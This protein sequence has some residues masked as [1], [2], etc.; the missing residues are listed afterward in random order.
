MAAEQRLHDLDDAWILATDETPIP[1]SPT[2][3]D[4]YVP[5]TETIL[6]SISSRA[7]VAAA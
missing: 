4:A 7:G 6:A 3:E 1:Y 5:D 2:L